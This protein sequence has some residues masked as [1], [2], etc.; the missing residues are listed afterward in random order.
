M[1]LL[2]FLGCV[3]FVGCYAALATASVGL[4]IRAGRWFAVYL[5]IMSVPGLLVWGLH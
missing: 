5:A 2:V 1:F 3:L 4:G